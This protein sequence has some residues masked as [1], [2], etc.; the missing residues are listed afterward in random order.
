MQKASHVLE[1][2]VVIWSTCLRS[3]SILS[4]SQWYLPNKVAANRHCLLLVTFKE[5][6]VYQWA[7]ISSFIEYKKN[8]DPTVL[9]SGPQGMH[10]FTFIC[11]KTKIHFALWK[12][13]MPAFKQNNFSSH[14][15]FS[16]NLS[17]TF[18]LP[19]LLS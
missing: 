10:I 13:Q 5:C 17:I 4:Y 2:T 7:L 9:S 19:F 12:Y 8:I 3:N 16:F 1:P 11:H 6:T 18:F 15:S 14:F